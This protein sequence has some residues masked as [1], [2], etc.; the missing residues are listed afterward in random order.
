M[1][2]VGPDDVSRRPPFRGKVLKADLANPVDREAV[3]AINNFF[4]GS[5]DQDVFGRTYRVLECVNF[6]ARPLPD[7]QGAPDPG[8]HGIAGNVAVT[9]E[10]GFLHI[11]VFHVWPS[12]QGR[13][14]GRKMLDAAII[15]ARS[16]G[17]SCIKLG[18]TNDNLPALYF[19]QRAGFV[20]EEMI[21]GEVASTHGGAPVGFAGIPVRDEIRLRLD[22]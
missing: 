3:E 10:D 15:E 6:L 19:Y 11:V 14:V 7:E 22:L 16:R 4:W 2:V 20:V 9:L 17:L 8:T 5:L 1:A 18:T 12:W 21:P 13:K